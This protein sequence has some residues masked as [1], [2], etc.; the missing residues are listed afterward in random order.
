MLVSLDRACSDVL[1]FDL[2][3]DNRDSK[4]ARILDPDDASVIGLIEIPRINEAVG[5]I[6]TA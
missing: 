1:Y 5:R 4:V 2:C 3:A 6:R